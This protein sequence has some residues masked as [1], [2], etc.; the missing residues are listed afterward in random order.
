MTSNKPVHEIRLGLIKVA[1]WH[2][3]TRVG[4]RHDVTHCRLFKNGD[5]WAQSQRY[6]RDDL[7]LLCKALD[8][9]HT[10]IYAQKHPDM[11]VEREVEL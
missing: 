4:D 7:L 11:A 6:G 10:W 9:A 1:I 5:V 2:K 8:Q 3:S